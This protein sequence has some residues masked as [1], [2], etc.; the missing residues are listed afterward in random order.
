LVLIIEIVRSL[1]TV[2]IP[3]VKDRVIK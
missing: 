3:S 2:S 1:V